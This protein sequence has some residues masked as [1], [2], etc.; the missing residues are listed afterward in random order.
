VTRRSLAV[1]AAIPLLLL[2]A[3]QRTVVVHVGGGPVPPPPPTPRQSLGPNE[4]PVIWLG[5]ALQE[6]AADQLTLHEDSGSVVTLRRLAEGATRFYQIAGRTWREL[7][8]DGSTARGQQTC[9]E[10]LMDGTNLLA[11]RVFLGSGCGPI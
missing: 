6:V 2:A 7:T 1:A 8:P 9:V 10:T 4:P 5:G 3:C 11:I